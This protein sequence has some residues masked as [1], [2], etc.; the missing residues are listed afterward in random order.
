MSVKDQK[1]WDFPGHPVVNNPLAGVIGSVP[2]PGRSHV[3][4]SN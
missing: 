1:S 3:P 4:Q 2:G